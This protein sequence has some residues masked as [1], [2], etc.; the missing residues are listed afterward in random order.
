MYEEGPSEHDFPKHI[1]NCDLL[2]TIYKNKSF[3]P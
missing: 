3:S 1:L 2:T